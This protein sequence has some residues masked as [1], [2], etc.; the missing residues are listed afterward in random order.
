VTRLA[1]A[2]TA[3]VEARRANY[4]HKRTREYL[5]VIPFN[6]GLEVLEGALAMGRQAEPFPA[7][8]VKTRLDLVREKACTPTSGEDYPFFSKVKDWLTAH[9]TV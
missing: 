9:E 8:E 4:I 7:D 6:I 5:Y 1:C 3:Q 2:D